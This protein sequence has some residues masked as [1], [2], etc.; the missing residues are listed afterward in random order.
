MQHG[1]SLTV[2]RFQI[3]FEG[4]KLAGMNIITVVSTI[5]FVNSLSKSSDMLCWNALVALYALYNKANNQRTVNWSH[6][7]LNSVTRLVK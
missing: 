4:Q 5:A 7:Q 1:K 3:A 2:E 6:D